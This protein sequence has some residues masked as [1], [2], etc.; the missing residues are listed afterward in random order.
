MK[1]TF[2]YDELFNAIQPIIGVVEDAFYDKGGRNII[3]RTVK[4]SN[5]LDIIGTTNRITYIEHFDGEVTITPSEDGSDF[6]DNETFL[7]QVNARELLSTLQVFKQLNRTRVSSVEITCAT[8]GKFVVKIYEVNKDK[9][10]DEITEADLLSS[11]ITHDVPKFTSIILNKVA[12]VFPTDG[13]I[14]TVKSLDILFHVQTLLPVMD[15]SGDGKS[16]YSRLVFSE[17]SIVAMNQAFTTIMTNQLPPCFNSIA[18]PHQ[19]ISFLKDVVCKEDTVEVASIDETKTLC[20]RGSNFDAFLLCNEASVAVTSYKNN[21]KTEHGIVIDRPYLRDVLKRLNLSND[22]VKVEFDIE[23]SMIK[24]SNKSFSQNVP[25]INSRG[26]EEYSSISFKVLPSTLDK[27]IIGMDDKFKTELFIYITKSVNKQAYTLS[28]SD[29]S[30]VWFS[31]LA[32][33]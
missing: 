1:F 16:N 14:T 12:Q 11:T 22:S 3:F 25:F 18:I 21:F 6:A 19:G 10:D 30:G 7:S 17:D 28:L 29:G 26:M 15:T 8:K 24:F 9:S 23:N 4:D 5:K 33:A 32:V 27:A 31:S 20:F 13:E 2:N